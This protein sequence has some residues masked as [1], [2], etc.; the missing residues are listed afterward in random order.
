LERF[1]NQIARDVVDPQTGVSLADRRR[2][3]MLV[4]GDETQRQ[5][6]AERDDLRIAALGS[7]SD[8]SPFLQH[9]GIASVHLSFSGEGPGGSYHTLYDTYEHYTSFRDPGLVYSDALARV[10]GRATLRLANARILPFEFTGFTD[11]I[12][13]YLSELEELADEMR[14][15][16][17]RAN[18][19][20]D[21]GIYD[22]ALDPTK[23]LGPPK[24]ESPVPYFNFAPLSNSLQLLQN[25]AASFEH[26]LA[27]GDV[28]ANE[29]AELNAFLYSSERLLTREAGLEGRP[30][31][32]HHIYAPGFY[33]GY[34]VKTIPG[35]RESI[36]QRSFDAVDSQIELAASVLGDMAERIEM[37]AGYLDP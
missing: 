15:E 4:S 36:E 9:L 26:A 35:V 29:L 34:G 14:T 28:R 10:A 31:Y 7:G 25:A 32:R 20:I 21:D 27:N 8:Y 18:A 22:I 30:W 6:V 16:T 3:R 23:P 11:T 33:T 17:A 5:E 1:F 2:A 37:A 24:A 19:L 13:L 12:E